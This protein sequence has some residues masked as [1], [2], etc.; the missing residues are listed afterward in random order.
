MASTMKASIVCA[1]IGSA[2]WVVGTVQAAEPMGKI[3]VVSGSVL[4][5]QS[6]RFVPAHE[7]MSLGE[8]DRIMTMEGGSATLVFR[9]GCRHTMAEL[10]KLTI[11]EQAPCSMQTAV[12]DGDSSVRFRPTAAPASAGT[13][14]AANLSWLPAA[15][16][17]VVPTGSVADS[18]RS[19]GGN[20]SLS[21]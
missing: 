21:P 13:G 6:G 14:A 2:F 10:Q 15:L 1:L 4:K 9:D 20:P 8:L 18:R 3:V 7:G 19:N 12:Y 17:G 11:G 16:G 5:S